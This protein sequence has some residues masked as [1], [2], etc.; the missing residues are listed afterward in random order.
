MLPLHPRIVHLPIA[1]AVLMPLVTSGLLLAW[2]RGW[3]PRRTW[4]VAVAL[5][6]A[7]VAGGFA[8][9]RTGEADEHQAETV[10][11]EPFIEAHE[12]A[13]KAMFLGALGVLALTGA[14]LALRGE[15]AARG[16][17]A[18]AVVGTLG[19]LF[20]A[21]RAGEAG[22]RLVYVHG[23]ASAYRPAVPPAPVPA[24]HH[25]DD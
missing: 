23:A 14:A 16:T 2:W 13:G 24:N 22:G 10:V 11:S 5:Q 7:L 19:V 17:A 3:L 12:D 8:A 20:L 6:V 21:W 9:L 15:A 18:L 25:E 1:L 4:V